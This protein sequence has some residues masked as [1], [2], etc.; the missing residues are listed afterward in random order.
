MTENNFNFLTSSNRCSKK[1][2]PV[3][4]IKFCPFVQKNVFA[5]G[6]SNRVEIH[7]IVNDKLILQKIYEIKSDEYL[8]ALDWSLVDE[9]EAILIAG[10]EYN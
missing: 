4:C 6:V 3:Y 10:G 9:V 1:K 8:Y 7:K 2:L 5:A